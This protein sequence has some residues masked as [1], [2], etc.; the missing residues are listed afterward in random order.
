MNSFN[1]YAYGSVAQWMFECAA[2]IRH[3]EQDAGFGRIVF[4]PLTD[5]RLGYVKASIETVHGVC[6]SEWRETDGAYTYTF[7]VP[8]GVTATVILPGKTAEIGAGTHSFT[9]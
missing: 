3:D 8:E 5:T 9:V 4:K 1:H 6:A 7:T 2:G